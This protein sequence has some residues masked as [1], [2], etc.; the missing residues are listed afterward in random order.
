MRAAVSSPELPQMNWLARL[1]TSM[2]PGFA[3]KDPDSKDKVE[4]QPRFPDIKLAHTS[5]NN[6]HA[7]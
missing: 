1:G 2:N 7:R 4:E 3:L 6:N 5:N